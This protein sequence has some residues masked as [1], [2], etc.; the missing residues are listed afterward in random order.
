MRRV[1][2]DEASALAGGCVASLLSTMPRD[3][4]AVARMSSLAAWLA[5]S[6]FATPRSRR[7]GP[8]EPARG[9]S[10]RTAAAER[11]LPA[12][13]VA[14]VIA[15][16]RDRLLRLRDAYGAEP[17]VFRSRHRQRGGTLRANRASVAGDAGRP[18]RARRRPFP[19]GTGYRFL[20]AAGNRQRAVSG[21]P[22]HQRAR[23][24]WS[25]A[26][27]MRRSSPGF[28]ASCTGSLSHLTVSNEQGAA[29]PAYRQPLAL[30]LRDTGS[31]R[32]HVH[33]TG[34][35]VAVR[36]LGVVAMA[37]VVAAPILQ[38]LAQGNGVIVPH[39]V[40][41][42]SADG[43]SRRGQ[44]ARSAGAARLR[45]GARTGALRPTVDQPR[46]VPPAPD[47]ALSATAATRRSRAAG[48]PGHRAL[49]TARARARRAGAPSPGGTRGAAADRRQP[50]VAAAAAIGAGHGCRA[51]SCRLRRN[52]ASPASTRRW[53]C[54][55]WVT[56][57]CWRALR[58]RR[59]SRTC[60]RSVGR[61]K[62]T[63]GSCSRADA[64]AV[65]D[66]CAAGAANARRGIAP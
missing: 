40:A 37:H 4:I 55:P 20:R 44:H 3:R 56:P 36:A 16:H 11:G 2:R 27:A 17:A 42:L 51:Y 9:R 14:D 25:R 15:P 53:R 28:A 49:A 12:I 54:G 43:A 26:G 6:G 45:A 47:S 23:H 8:A 13:D 66:E 61:R 34:T 38:Y 50:R 33:W 22:D 1:K 60:L 39:L 24:A 41:A 62:R 65:W 35:T 46:C 19:A 58:A 7:A 21:A 29:W 32:Y 31:R 10:R 64:S 57:A 52:R 63:R 59:Q 5:Q 30:W 48:A 18:V